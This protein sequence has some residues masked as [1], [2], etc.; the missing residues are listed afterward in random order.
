MA[1]LRPAVAAFFLL[2]VPAVF[3]RCGAEG[4]DEKGEARPKS[5]LGEIVDLLFPP[6]HAAGQAAETRL[7]TGGNLTAGNLLGGG[8]LTPQE[9]DYMGPFSPLEAAES[10]QGKL[11][12]LTRLG[13]AEFTDRLPRAFWEDVFSMPSVVLANTFDVGLLQYVKEIPTLMCIALWAPNI[14]TYEPPVQ[15]AHNLMLTVAIFHAVAAFTDDWHVF[16]G[17]DRRAPKHMRTHRNRQEAGVHACYE[18]QRILIPRAAEAFKQVMPLL[19]YNPLDTEADEET[20]AGLGNLV[21]RET[22]EWFNDDGYNRDGTMLHEHNGLP[23]ED[24]TGYKPVNDP[25]ELVYPTYWQPLIEVEGLDGSGTRYGYNVVQQHITP[26][27]G[28]VRPF[29]LTQQQVDIR[30]SPPIFNCVQDTPHKRDPGHQGEPPKGN[31]TSCVDVL[32]ERAWKVIEESLELDEKKKAI[33]EYFDNKL[34]SLGS[35]LLQ[36]IKPLDMTFEEFTAIDLGYVGLL[37]DATIVAWKEKIFHEAVRPQSF[38]QHFLQNET[39]S[40]YVPKEGVKPI[41]GRDWK[42]Y[43]R[44]MPHTACLCRA[45]MEFAKTAFE[46]FDISGKLKAYFPK[47]SSLVETGMSP[48]T[49]LIVEWES[50]DEIATV[51]AE[52]RLWTGVHFEPAIDPQLGGKLCDGIGAIVF[53]RVKGHSGNTLDSKDMW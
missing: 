48:T 51:C 15:N 18:F 25:Y 21:A 13:L 52:S 14:L 49:D 23:Y 8:F 11:Q 26:Q 3:F 31:D 19:G 33:G 50:F 12:A 44:T 27:A 36:L 16:F 40:A 38:I 46:G 45:T 37:H 29:F 7:E 47:G 6:L 9:S 39:F 43:F 2:L 32:K 34:Y 20:A 53:E 17:P 24:W 1:V 35:T 22:V 5:P 4:P 42:S 10:L 41:M 28:R 30:R